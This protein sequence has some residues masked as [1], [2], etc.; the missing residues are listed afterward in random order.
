MKKLPDKEFAMPRGKAT[1]DGVGYFAA[2]IATH[3][4]PVLQQDV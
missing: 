1:G 3:A 4:F 2:L